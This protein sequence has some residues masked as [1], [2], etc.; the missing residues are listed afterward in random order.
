MLFSIQAYIEE[1][2]ASKN[3]TDTDGYAVKLANLYYFNRLNYD[4]LNFTNKVNRIH[5]LIFY[6]NSISDRRAFIQI[7]VNRVDYFFKAS[8]EKNIN[9]FPGGTIDELKKIQQKPK[10]TIEFLLS[11]FS[12]ATEARAIDAFWISRI[13]GNLRQKPEKIGQTLFT[14]FAM[15]T[16]LNRPG[17]A[18]REFQSGIGYVDVGII[19]CSILHLVEIKVM[20]KDF[21]GTSQLDQYMASENRPEGSLLVFDTLIPEKKIVLPKEI[22]CSSGII[23]VYKVDINPIPPSRVK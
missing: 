13:K 3:I 17:L 10:L 19:F 23:K 6:S 8:L 18:L 9:T 5:S 16:L 15:G 21:T 22:P 4:N 11:E 12:K 1:Y 2:L 7:L 20:V 14:L